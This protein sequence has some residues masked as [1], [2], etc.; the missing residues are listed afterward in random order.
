MIIRLR[1]VVNQREKTFCFKAAN[2]MTAL[3]RANDIGDKIVAFHSVFLGRSS[4]NQVCAIPGIQHGFEEFRGETSIS[5][6]ME[7][8][9]VRG[10]RRVAP[11]DILLIINQSFVKANK[12]NRER[13]N[14][15]V[16]RKKRTRSKLTELSIATSVELAHL[17][18]V[19]VGC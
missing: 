13:Q 10:G 16:K 1:C 15:W 9:G 17:M 14:H 19:S 18:S 11:I 6:D 2:G 7:E 5:V 3:N 4:S 8:Q 12:T